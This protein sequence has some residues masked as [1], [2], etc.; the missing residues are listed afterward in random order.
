MHVSRCSHCNCLIIRKTCIGSLALVGIVHY[1]LD[2][3]TFLAWWMGDSL[4]AMLAAPFLIGLNVENLSKLFEKRIETLCIFAISFFV[5][6]VCFP[7]NN[8]GNNLHLPIVFTSFICVAWAALRLGL[9]GSALCTIGFSFIA[10]WST[11]HQLGPFTATALPISYYLIW[12]YSASL[13]LLSLMITIASAEIAY[14]SDR[15]IEMSI[16][17]NEQQKHF[18]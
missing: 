5:A 2:R 15:L 9:V 18:E 16:A 13:T 8:V 6:L 10:I 7:L 3:Y 14:K 1:D 11:V 17:R 12:L 4:G